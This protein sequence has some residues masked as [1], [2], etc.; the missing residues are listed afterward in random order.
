MGMFGKFCKHQLAIMTLFQQ[1]F[2]N[3]PSMTAN[4]RH[5]IA[6]I[7]LGEACPPTDF[8]RDLQQV[9]TAEN[10]SHQNSA[11]PVIP[12]SGAVQVL[13]PPS[14]SSTSYEHTNDSSSTGHLIDEYC[15]LIRELHSK[16]GG[17]AECQS[18]LEKALCRL[19]SISSASLFAAYLH[20]PGVS[21][22]YR[23]GAS[24]RVQPTALSRRRVG[25]TRGSKRLASGRPPAQTGV[26]RAKRR[27]CLSLNIRAN[28]PNAKSHGSGH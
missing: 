1:A 26:P 10:P 28:V 20:N 25:V 6:Y 15:T 5:S 9:D 22:R 24:I 12:A 14:A 13:L 7:A 23:A 11:E 19:K 3:A 27:R 18:G 2:P 21:R 16:F 8:Y 17:V 4:K